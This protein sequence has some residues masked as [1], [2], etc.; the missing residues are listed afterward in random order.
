MPHRRRYRQTYAVHPLTSPGVPIL[1][2]LIPAVGFVLTTLRFILSAV[3]LDVF[4]A[5]KKPQ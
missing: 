5:I 3:N 4:K 1:H 2:R